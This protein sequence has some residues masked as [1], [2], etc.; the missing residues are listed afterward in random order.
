MAR[1]KATRAKAAFDDQQLAPNSTPEV[2]I[3]FA[4]FYVSRSAFQ[5]LG[6]TVTSAPSLAKESFKVGV[7]VRISVADS[8]D[9][10]RV[11]MGL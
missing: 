4:G 2:G 8:G 11:E 7:S 3:K 9:S 5:D 6:S 10:V 1:K